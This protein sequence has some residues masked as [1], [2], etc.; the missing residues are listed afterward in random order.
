MVASAYVVSAFAAEPARPKGTSM[1]G[2]LQSLGE[3]AGVAARAPWTGFARPARYEGVNAGATLRDASGWSASLF[4]AYVDRQGFADE[5][6][7]R[8]VSTPVVNAVVSRRLTKSSRLAFDVINVLDRQP[9]GF[10]YLGASRAWD[11]VASDNFLFH[12]A[13][14]RGFRLRLRVTF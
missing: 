9:A 1:E 14:P 4:V 13:E 12:P 10:D 5:P 6:S 11:A 8:L 3:G 2:F 7:A